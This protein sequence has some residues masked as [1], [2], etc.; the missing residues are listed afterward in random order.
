MKEHTEEE[1]SIMSTEAITQHFLEIRSIILAGKANNKNI[2]NLE[3]Y[4]CYITKEIENR[5]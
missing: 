5:K 3:I 4:F 1:L 2:K